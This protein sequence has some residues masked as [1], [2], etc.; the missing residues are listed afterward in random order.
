MFDWGI[1][2]KYIRQRGD[3]PITSD[4]PEARADKHLQHGLGENHFADE[5][6]G[7][8]CRDLTNCDWNN[9]PGQ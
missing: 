4:D 8:S 6:P 5:F 3:K 9:E 1:P 2:A 7:S